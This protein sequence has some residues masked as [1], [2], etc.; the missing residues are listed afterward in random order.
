MRD[1]RIRMQEGKSCKGQRP[2]NLVSD[3]VP[4]TTS[5][6]SDTAY[7]FNPRPL[8]FTWYVWKTPCPAD[9]NQLIGPP[10]P[11]KP[12]QTNNISLSTPFSWSP[13]IPQNWGSKRTQ[14]HQRL[15]PS[16]SFPRFAGSPVSD[17][18]Q[19]PP[20]ARLTALGLEGLGPRLGQQPWHQ[21]EER[22]PTRPGHSTIVQE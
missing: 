22:R 13:K 12:S 21:G 2:T 1:T 4:G 6:V 15:T 10:K 3:N 7:V 18:E 9:P 19:L 20:P 11:P 14:K 5:R 17:S 8:F 16:A